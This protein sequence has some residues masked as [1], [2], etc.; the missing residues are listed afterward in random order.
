M[1]I[2]MPKG[3]ILQENNN[4]IN[5]ALMIAFINCKVQTTAIL[6]IIDF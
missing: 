2:F 1:D 5:I 6:I 3:K 4:E